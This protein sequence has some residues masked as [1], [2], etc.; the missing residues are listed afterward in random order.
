[1]FPLSCRDMVYCNDCKSCA[2]RLF[3]L[4][5]MKSA[6]ASAQ[7]LTAVTRYDREID[8]EACR[9]SVMFI[10]SSRTLS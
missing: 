10:V 7:P 2:F 1:M 9:D 4:V 8:V 5:Q 6:V 3:F